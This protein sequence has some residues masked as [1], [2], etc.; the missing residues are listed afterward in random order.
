M[1]VNPPTFMFFNV[2]GLGISKVTP[3]G[4]QK[5]DYIFKVLPKINCVIFMLFFHCHYNIVSYIPYNIHET[6][7][8]SPAPLPILNPPPP[9]AIVCKEIVIINIF[10]AL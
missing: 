9:L 1:S 6:S 5:L 7:P 10:N 3:S 2:R 4:N 8:P